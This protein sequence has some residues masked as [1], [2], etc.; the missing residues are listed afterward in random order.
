MLN[1]VKHLANVSCNAP[2]EILRF[3]QDDRDLII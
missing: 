3:T 2:R 1:K